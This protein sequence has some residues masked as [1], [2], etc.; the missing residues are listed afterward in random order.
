MVSSAWLQAASAW[1]EINTRAAL[2]QVDL[3][4]LRCDA[5]QAAH[6]FGTLLWLAGGEET[7][8]TNDPAFGEALVTAHRAYVELST[9]NSWGPT[10]GKL[11]EPGPVFPAHGPRILGTGSKN[12]VF[13]PCPHTGSHRSPGQTP[14]LPFSMRRIPTTAPSSA[15][16][17]SNSDVPTVGPT[18]PSNW[19]CP[20]RLKA[21]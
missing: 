12:T 11:D 4:G 8:A 14:C 9:E 20:P 13:P 7:T 16:S 21:G 17:C 2:N 1:E 6:A 19:T 5:E 18:S 10:L 15:S 3:G